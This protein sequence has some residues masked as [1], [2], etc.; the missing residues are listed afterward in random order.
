[1]KMENCSCSLPLLASDCD[2]ET[3]YDSLAW[4]INTLWGEITA[5]STTV[6][7]ASGQIRVVKLDG[8]TENSV[9]E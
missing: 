1:M 3:H 5:W 6:W 9:F 4:H 8:C 7:E 2:S